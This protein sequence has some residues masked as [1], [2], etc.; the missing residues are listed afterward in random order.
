MLEVWIDGACEPINPGG[1]ASYGLIIKRQ[2]VA[3]KFSEIHGNKLRLLM[4]KHVVGNGSTMSN[5]VA[6]YSALLAFLG[7]YYANITNKEEATIY[8]D[9]KLVVNQMN[10]LWEAKQGL[11][12][13]YYETAF[14]MLCSLAPHNISFRWIPREEN[15]EADNLSKQALLAIGIKPRH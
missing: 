13:P 4:V 10:G 3:D 1:T 2:I 14:N 11:Y 8:S 7:W 9:S 12:I 5:N 15:Y 6:E